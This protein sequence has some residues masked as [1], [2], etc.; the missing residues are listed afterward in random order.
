MWS[1]FRGR[2]VD[3]MAFW[4]NLNISHV[5]QR[6]TGAFWV[7]TLKQRWGYLGYFTVN[8]QTNFKYYCRIK[9]FEI[10]FR[11][12]FEDILKYFSGT[13]FEYRPNFKVVVCQSVLI[14]ARNIWN[15]TSFLWGVGSGLVWWL[16]S[17]IIFEMHGPY[18]GLCRY[19]IF[20]QYRYLMF[21]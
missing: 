19:D 15:W 2:G 18:P 5:R 14:P 4:P 7:T 11:N 3:W 17:H 16:W 1:T 9:Y 20:T 21:L 8:V 12:I 10:P 6:P 13:L